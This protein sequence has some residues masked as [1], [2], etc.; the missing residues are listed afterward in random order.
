MRMLLAEYREG[1]ARLERSGSPALAARLDE[2]RRI[3]LH[4]T[5]RRLDAIT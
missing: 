4:E 3:Y 1:L 2:I 5:G